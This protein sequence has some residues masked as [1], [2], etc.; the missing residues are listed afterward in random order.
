DESSAW[1]H[2]TKHYGTSKHESK[3]PAWLKAKMLGLVK[4]MKYKRTSVREA[5]LLVGCRLW[6]K[7]GINIE[8]TEADVI[9]DLVISNINADM[10]VRTEFNMITSF[11][12]CEVIKQGLKN[13][14]V[15][16]DESDRKTI[17]LTVPTGAE[18]EE[19][20]SLERV[21]ELSTNGRTWAKSP[22]DADLASTIEWPYA[23]PDKVRLFKQQQ[24]AMNA[25][26]SII[27]AEAAVR[28][29]KYGTLA[30]VPRNKPYS[31]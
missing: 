22:E 29:A 25:I 14:S 13:E 23:D 2:L 26:G 24:M 8:S 6:L 3:C 18:G 17:M 27:S 11:I 4:D 28:G 7:Y 12:I 5:I 10:G 30:V 16:I 15:K 1:I 31:N 19:E 9:V 21:I 20:T